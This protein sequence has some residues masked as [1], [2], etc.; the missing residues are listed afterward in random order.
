M[1]VLRSTTLLDAEPSAVA[2]L[3]RDTEVAVAACARAGHRFAA[4]NRLLSPGDEMRLTA[5]LLPGVRLPSTMLVTEISPAGMTSVLVRGPLRAL[6]HTNT[7]AAAA[8]GTLLIDE[9]CWT[10]PGGAVADVV[11]VRR[12]VRRLLATRAEV[13]TERVTA[14]ATAAV[15]VATALVRDGTVLA[16]RRSYPPELAGR[17]E[18][19]G[20]RV[21]PGETEAE[22]VVRECREELGTSVVPGRRLGPDLPIR[23][24]VLRVH[25]AVPAAGAEDP[26]A[27]EHS[28]LRWVTA[29]ELGTVGW[30]DADRAVVHDLAGLL[31]GSGDGGSPGGPEGS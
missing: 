3:L 23:A 9:L 20:G 13:L 24:G 29:P 25:T 18:L 10:T 15:V 1:P 21:E 30:L 22:A 5:R 2:G 11:L 26:R 14:L 12:L 16:A 8:A 19:P 28:A 31:G 6:R 7:L 4:T 27:L 17:W